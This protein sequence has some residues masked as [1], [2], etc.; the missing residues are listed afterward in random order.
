MKE[1][2]NS[3]IQEKECGFAVVIPLW[4]IGFAIFKLYPF[5]SS[6][7]KALS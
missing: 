6:L 2:R 5:V 1:K 4:W 7:I 3:N